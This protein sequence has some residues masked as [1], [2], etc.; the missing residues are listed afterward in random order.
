MNSLEQ[1]F[2]KEMLNVYRNAKKRCNYRAI[3]FFR[4]VNEYG[5]LETAMRLLRTD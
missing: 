4:M 2:H 3:I 5:G 1:R